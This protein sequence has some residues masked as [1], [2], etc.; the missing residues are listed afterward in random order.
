M[1]SHSFKN[2]KTL[3]HFFE[4]LYLMVSSAVAGIGCLVDTT[5][6]TLF[7]RFS[8]C[9]FWV[10][11]YNLSL[12]PAAFTLNTVAAFIGILGIVFFCSLLKNTQSHP[13]CGHSHAHKVHHIHCVDHTTCC[14]AWH[15][16]P[17]HHHP[18]PSNHGVH[19]LLCIHLPGLGVSGVSG[20]LDKVAPANHITYNNCQC[21]RLKPF[22]RA[23][24]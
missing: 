15:Q 23:G 6:I 17:S 21:H 16:H 2:S 19:R 8:T 7:S 11:D 24:F 9:T 10:S 14:H 1:P 5:F 3:E 12:S 18:H 4:P 20:Q 22:T 13:L